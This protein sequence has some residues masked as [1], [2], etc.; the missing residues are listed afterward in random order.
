MSETIVWGVNAKVDGVP[1]G[2]GYGVRFHFGPEPERI[3]GMGAPIA[4]GGPRPITVWITKWINGGYRDYKQIPADVVVTG[5]TETGDAFE[6][7]DY[8]L[9]IT[10]V[11]EQPDG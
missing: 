3:I 5:W 6:F 4:I 7:S 10:S 2:D 11:K 8:M 1:L 9:K